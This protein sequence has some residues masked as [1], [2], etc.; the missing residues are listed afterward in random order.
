MEALQILSFARPG[1]TAVTARLYAADAPCRGILY[2]HVSGA[3]EKAA[4]AALA[5]KAIAFC[6]LSGEDWEADLS[7]WPAPRAFK[8]GH[9]FSGGAAQYLAFLHETVLPEAEKSLGLACPRR[10]LAGYSLAGLFAIY[11]AYY[12]DD[13][14]VLASMSGSLWY[15][16]FAA[17]CTENRPLRVPDGIY[18][19]LGSREAKT[20]DPRMAAV[21]DATKAVQD[22]FARLG[23]KTT[24]YPENGGHFEQIEARCARGVSAAAALLESPL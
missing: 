13:Y 9:D 20:R 24:F 8:K 18:F 4:V 2:T 10:A 23:T 17:F 1:K 7:P 12:C 16:G 3:D 5:G 21:G 14:C 22:C 19:S 15:D 6:A 11:S